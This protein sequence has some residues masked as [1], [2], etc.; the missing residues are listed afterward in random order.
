MITF[1]QIFLFLGMTTSL[2]FLFTKHSQFR[3]VREKVTLENKKNNELGRKNYL[4]LF[5]YKFFT[6][7]YCCGFWCGI[8]SLLAVRYCEFIPML[9]M[10]AFVSFLILN[11][12]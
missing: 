12:E 11:R 8:L 6:C 7:D 1:V 10:G 4:T 9:F 5:F 2:V 3:P